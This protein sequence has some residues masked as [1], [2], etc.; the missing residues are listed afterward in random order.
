MPA[1]SR[2]VAIMGLIL[3]AACSG[4]QQSA[5]SAMIIKPSS[6]DVATTMDRLEAEVH[7]RGAKVVAVIDH[8][9]AGRKSGIDLPDMQVLIFGDPK[10]GSP[11]IAQYPK[12]GIDLPLKVLV[13]QDKQGHTQMGFT[14][15]IKMGQWYGI[16]ATDPTLTKMRGV[17]E[18][19]T[20]E[21]GRA[22]KP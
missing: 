10:Q 7:E 13:W 3:L 18:H 1:L 21:A 14:D 22:D 8:G 16:E 9:A 20:R 15:P 2:L 6:Y 17:L 12:I 4:T 19:V 5:D 11:L